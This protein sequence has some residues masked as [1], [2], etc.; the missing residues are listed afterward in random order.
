MHRVRISL[1]HFSEFGWTPFVLAVDPIYVE[2]VIEPLLLETVPKDIPVHRVKAIPV[3]WARKVGIG[4]VGVRALPFLYRAG[5]NII[6]HHKIDLVYLSTTAFVAMTL[7]RLWK[8]KYGIPFALDMQDPWVGDYYEHKPKAERPRKYWLSSRLHRIL[9]PWTMRRVDGI[10]AVSEAYHETLRRRYP[11]ISVERC[12]TIP[13]GAARADFDVAARVTNQNCFFQ[14]GDGLLHG[15]YAGVLGPVMKETCAALCLA[16]RQGLQRYPAL[17]SKVRLHFLGTDYA[18]GAKARP[19]IQP[20]AAKMGLET[21]IQEHPRRLSFM[22][23]LNLLKQA[24]FLLL[25]GSDNPHYT[26][27][28]IYPYILAQRPLFAVF[29]E[30][31]SV[32]QVL[33]STHAG[34]VVAFS[35]ERSAEIATLIVPRLAEFLQRLPFQPSTDWQALEPYTAREMTR[36][37][38]DLFDQIVEAVPASLFETRQPGTPDSA[39]QTYRI[40]DHDAPPTK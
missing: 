12:R 15:V 10:I 1:P 34:E 36:R 30:Q 6:Q 19:T 2:R 32:V 16:F 28:K 21:Y 25:P 13:I 20:M 35:S 27:S 22:E 23:V 26:A 11:W 38:C 17:F 24:D 40:D 37:Q 3:R 5:A 9:E 18:T 8:E 39:G 33:R 4:D 7:G 29:H 14:I 31:S